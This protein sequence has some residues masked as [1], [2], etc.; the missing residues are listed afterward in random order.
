[1]WIDDDGVL[2]T[3]A[4]PDPTDVMTVE[5]RVGLDSI[6]GVRRDALR[7]LIEDAQMRVFETTWSHLPRTEDYVGAAPPTGLLRGEVMAPEDVARVI[8]DVEARWRL[9]AIE[10]LDDYIE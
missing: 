10:A 2:H 7:A 3:V 8:D 4:L 5:F 9:D 6:T 1:V